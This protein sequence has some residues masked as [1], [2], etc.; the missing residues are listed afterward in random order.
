MKIKILD[1]V[2]EHQA[3]QKQIYR[4]TIQPAHGLPGNDFPAKE[5][6]SAQNN[7]RDLAH[8]GKNINERVYKNHRCFPRRSGTFSENGAPAAA[9]LNRPHHFQDLVRGLLIQDQVKIPLHI[10]T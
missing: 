1:Q 5:K 10:Q 3:G 9:G 4:Q 7:H 2:I 8:R 6:K